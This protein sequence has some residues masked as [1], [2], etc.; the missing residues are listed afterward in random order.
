M[1][2]SATNAVART[3]KNSPSEKFHWDFKPVLLQRLKAEH[4]PIGLVILVISVLVCGFLGRQCK[5]GETGQNPCFNSNC[6]FIGVRAD[7]YVSFPI[8][9]VA[10]MFIG[11]SK[12][13]CCFRGAYWPTSRSVY[14]PYLIFSL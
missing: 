14:S 10:T 9:S 8:L 12:V 2:F 5:F 1:E 4:H 3:R 7:C 6:L 13:G 11:P